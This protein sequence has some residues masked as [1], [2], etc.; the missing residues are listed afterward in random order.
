MPL[1]ES[2]GAEI[3]KQA[4]I[5][6]A[7]PPIVRRVLVVDDN[8]DVA[9]SLGLLLQ[10]L[11]VDVRVTYDGRSALEM[12]SA[13]KPEMVFLDLGMPEM[14][15]YETARRLRQLPDGRAV[16]LVALTGRGQE[17]DRRRSLQAGFDKHL[18]KPVDV[19]LLQAL[20][21]QRRRR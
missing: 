15:G 2:D 14:D 7:A 1:A 18:V 21:A 5:G 6:A 20:L 12:I 17:E 16:Q 8:R 4:A 10:S 3:P 19:K 13:L 9:D 11:N